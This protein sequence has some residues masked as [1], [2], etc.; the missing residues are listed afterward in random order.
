MPLCILVVEF[1]GTLVA[2]FG[3]LLAMSFLAEW[4]GRRSLAKAR[5]RVQLY[6]NGVMVRFSRIATI[7]L[8]DQA[9]VEGTATDVRR[10]LA[11]HI[12]PV[13]RGST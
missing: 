1:D 11:E 5:N 8:P 3:G 12:K 10:L 9:L 6:P 4:W 7:W 13:D 2:M